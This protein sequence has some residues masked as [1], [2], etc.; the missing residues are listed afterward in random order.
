MKA[1][2]RYRLGRWLLRERFAM[3]EAKENK[4]KNMTDATWAEAHAARIAARE[5]L[6]CFTYVERKVV[7][8]P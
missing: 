2:W 6:A 8:T 1:T 5:I 3:A 4:I 7:P